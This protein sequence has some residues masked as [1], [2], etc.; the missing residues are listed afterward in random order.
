MRAG[1]TALLKHPAV[2]YIAPFAV[3]MAFVLFGSRLPIEGWGQPLRVVVVSAVLYCCSRGVIDPRVRLFLG[4]LGLGLAVFVVWI[5]PDLLWPGYRG[6][7]LF[8][9]A[10]TGKA[11]GSLSADVRGEWMVLVFRTIRA[12]IL[13]PIIE[14]LFWRAWLMRWLIDSDFR[15]VPL[16][17]YTARSFWITALLFAAVSLRHADRQVGVLAVRAGPVSA[18]DRSSSVK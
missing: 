14:E 9:N 7:W 10:L 4:S 5:G 15:R 13:V 18:G 16:G 12:A 3:L 1:Q 8:E 11:A 17:T 6:H 2:A